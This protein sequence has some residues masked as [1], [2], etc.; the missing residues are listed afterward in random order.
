VN[1]RPGLAVQN[2]NAEG[3]GRRIEFVRG[4][5]DGAEYRPVTERVTLAKSWDA[6]GW[7]A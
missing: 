3:V 5:L 1:K 2:A 6:G 4:R 7:S